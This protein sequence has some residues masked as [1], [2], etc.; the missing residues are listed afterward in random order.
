M[1]IEIQSVETGNV[2]V[3][4]VSGNVNSMTAI[5]MGEFLEKASRQGQHNIVLELGG[6]EYITSAGM[7]EILSGVK[8]AQMDGGDLRIANPSERVTELLNITG[9]TKHLSI[10]DSREAAV[11]SFA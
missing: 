8:R 11:Q 3:V 10:F 5:Q 6:V 9:L 1:S 4:E 2:L 7:R